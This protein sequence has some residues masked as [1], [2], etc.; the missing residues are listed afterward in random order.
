MR[1]MRTGMCI[2]PAGDAPEDRTASQ[3]GVKPVDGTNTTDHTGAE[4]TAVTA[5]IITRAPARSITAVIQAYHRMI[6]RSRRRTAPHPLL[7]GQ[8]AAQS[9]KNRH[10]IM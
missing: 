7:K 2:S 9:R 4:A 3:D 1:K 10:K 8:K 6:L 5:H